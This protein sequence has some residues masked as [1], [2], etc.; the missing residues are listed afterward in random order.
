MGKLLRRLTKLVFY[1]GLAG[2]AAAGLRALVGRLS[3]EPGTPSAQ[4]GSYD[5]WPAVAR[6]PGREEAET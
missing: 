2:A 1:V 6:A 4:G 3:G 5:S